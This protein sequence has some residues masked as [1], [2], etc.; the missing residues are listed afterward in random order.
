MASVGNSVRKAIEDWSIGDYEF[1]MLHACNAIDGTAKKI[2][3]NLQNNA[4]FTKLIRDNYAIFGPMGLPGINLEDTRWPIAVKSPKAPGGLPD[5]ADVIYG[6]HRC[7]HGHGDELPDGFDLWPNASV[8][9]GKTRTCIERGKI[10]LS[11]RVIFALLGVAVL[12]KANIGQ[13]VPEGYFL[14]FADTVMPI[15]EWWGRADDFVP[16]VAAEQLPSVILNFPNW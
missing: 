16:L 4:R 11:D 2:F 3:P 10:Q 8:K 12:S 1:A 5:I 14:S 7:T 6:V 15:N 13:I 9:D